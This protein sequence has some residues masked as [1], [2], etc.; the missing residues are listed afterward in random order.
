MSIT[1]EFTILIYTFC[2]LTISILSLLILADFR[3]KI[4][5]K[6]SWNINAVR[7]EK[8]DHFRSNCERYHLTSR[9]LEV[10]KLMSTG[11]PYKIIGDEL[12]I[13]EKTVKNHV[14]NMY[15]KTNVSNKMELVWLMTQSNN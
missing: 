4:M 9:E 5:S 8:K 12:C 10:L 14:L 7:D 6:I 1:T 11:K 2:S 13:S 3:K 15:Q